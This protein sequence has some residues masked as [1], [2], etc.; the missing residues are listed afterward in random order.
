M[1][2]GYIIYVAERALVR[3][4]GAKATGPNRQ[5]PGPLSAVLDERVS[6]SLMSI[7]EMSVQGVGRGR[8]AWAPESWLER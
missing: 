7:A 2:R 4:R 3:L 1:F 5:L 6:A 8:F